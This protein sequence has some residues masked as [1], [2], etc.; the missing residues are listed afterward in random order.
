MSICKVLQETRK[1]DFQIVESVNYIVQYMR[2]LLKA[3]KSY[4]YSI[5]RHIAFNF[6]V[7]GQDELKILTLVIWAINNALYGLVGLRL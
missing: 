1:F 3:H 6:L 4:F 5:L 2:L 7:V